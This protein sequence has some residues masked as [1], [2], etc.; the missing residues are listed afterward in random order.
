MRMTKAN[1]D[2]SPAVTRWTQGL[3]LLL[4]AAATGVT[5]SGCAGL[6]VKKEEKPHILFFDSEGLPVAHSKEEGEVA[7]DRKA[8]RERAT[9]ILEAVKD[10]NPKRIVLFMHGGLTGNDTALETLR[11]TTKM[12]EMF[13]EDPQ[14]D[15]FPILI[16]WDTSF[17]SSY[18]YNVYR[19]RE[20]KAVAA[21]SPE[22]WGL[23]APY[24]FTDFFVTTVEV[25][26]DIASNTIFAVDDALGLRLAEPTDGLSLSP[27]RGALKVYLGADRRPVMQKFFDW[28]GWAPFVG[29]K[30]PS[31]FAIQLGGVR[32]WKE[33]VRRSNVLFVNATDEWRGV[34]ARPNELAAL[35]IFLRE[36]FHLVGDINAARVAKGQ[37]PIELS[38]V[39]HS[40]G[41]ILV[42]KILNNFG[43]ETG[44][45]NIVYMANAASLRDTHEAVFRALRQPVGKNS[46]VYHL[47][48]HEIAEI[49]ERPVIFPGWPRWLEILPRGSLLVW[50]DRQFTNPTDFLDRRAGRLLNLLPTLK[51]TPNE[52]R[53]RIHVK[54]F[55]FGWNLDEGECDYEKDPSCWERF[56][57]QTHE[58]FDELPYWRP[59][60]WEPF[61]IVKGG[62]RYLP[63]NESCSEPQIETHP[64]QADRTF[65][66]CEDLPWV[67]VPAPVAPPVAA[68]PKRDVEKKSPPAPSIPPATPVDEN[69]STDPE[70]DATLPT[71]PPTATPKAKAEETTPTPPAPKTPAPAPSGAQTP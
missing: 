17:M 66:R 13:G 57:P 27:E 33:M 14:K 36:L 47:V 53:G 19:V 49:H 65:G 61:A 34:N 21:T 6:D 2:I 30:V 51:Q 16:A 22:A 8:F 28:F 48:L 1:F 52:M 56:Q 42:N 38:L 4:L 3:A 31:Q 39:G 15:T 18:F 9:T 40:T 20:G 62:R 46:R 7:L 44:F 50:L 41:G 12:M 5:A 45:D 54:A 71:V 68:P 67:S 63:Q 25:P 35:P 55:D 69:P 60:F 10:N 59:E 11:D 58:S 43:H 64:D 70:S 26:V 23:V 37:E 24:A 29:T 32:A